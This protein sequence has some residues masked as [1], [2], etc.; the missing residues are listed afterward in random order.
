MVC[1]VHA[2]HVDLTDELGRVGSH[3]GGFD[4]GPM[5]GRDRHC[6]C[7]V[8]DDEDEVVR[9]EPR[10]GHAGRQIRASQSALLGVVGERSGVGGQPNSLVATDLEASDVEPG[11]QLSTWQLSVW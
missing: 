4:L 9:V 3:A 6:R 2:N 1:R 7:I 11:R 8:R 10:F 5:E